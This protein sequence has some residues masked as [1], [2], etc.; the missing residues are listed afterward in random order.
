MTEELTA[1][2]MQLSD[3]LHSK[4]R[5]GKKKKL[6]NLA[7]HSGIPPVRIFNAFVKLML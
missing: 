1:L 7:M 2:E 4:K 3:S 6:E 5:K